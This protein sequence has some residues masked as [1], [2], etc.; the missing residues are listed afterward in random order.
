M[1]FIPAEAEQSLFDKINSG[2]ADTLDWVYGH[3]IVFVLII[4]LVGF[5]IYST[6][7]TRAIQFRLFGHMWHVALNSRDGAYGGISSFQA[8][9]VGLADRIGTGNIAGVAIALVVGGPGAVFWMWIIALLGMA[10]GFIESTLGQMFKVR[11]PDGTFRGG[12]AFYIERG[13]GKRGW[14]VL[15]SVLLVFTFA[16]A[17]EMIQANTLSA[18]AAENFGWPTWVSAIVLVLISAP[19]FIGGL[20]PVA[21]FTEILAPLMAVLYILLALITFITNWHM[22]IPVFQTIFASAFGLNQAAGG[23]LGGIY[24]AFMNGAKRGLFSNEAGEG[25]VPNAASTATVNHPVKQGLI[26]SLGVFVDTILVCTATAFIV[27][28]GGVFDINATEQSQVVQDLS[29]ANLTIESLGVLGAWTKPVMIIIIFMFIYSTLLGNYAYAEGN[30]KFLRGIDSK[31][32]FSKIICIVAV[33]LGAV[34]SLNAVWVIGDWAA[35]LLVL[36]NLT[37]CL[38]LYKWAIGALKDYEHQRKTK[39]EEEILFC[40]TDNE[41]LP[42]ELPT[43]IWSAEGIA[44]G[45]HIGKAAE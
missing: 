27:L 3:S 18:I 11:N 43:D 23:A 33:F 36:V 6:I 12:P 34:M 4:L 17:Y 10:T 35:A 8:F 7:K 21:R 25:S 19:F 45:R 15:F 26:Q 31:G 40:S 20:R 9:T 16:F 13:L 22:I 5:G 44:A 32:W 28:V 29:G 1:F 2:I 24:A 39:P 41:F 14:G 42:G 38:F 37:A 30:E